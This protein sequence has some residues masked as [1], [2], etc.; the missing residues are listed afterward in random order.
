MLKNNKENSD[1][2]EDSLFGILLKKIS[3]NKKIIINNY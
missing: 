2:Q 1:N 3:D